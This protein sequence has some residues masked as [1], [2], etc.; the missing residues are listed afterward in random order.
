MSQTDKEIEGEGGRKERTIHGRDRGPDSGTKLAR[1]EL[2]P[3]FVPGIECAVG[4][5]CGEV[6]F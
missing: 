3:S 6:V 5:A 1:Y 2:R 4:I